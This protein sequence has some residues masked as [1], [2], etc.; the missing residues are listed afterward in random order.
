MSSAG[1][2]IEQH[3]S[4]FGISGASWTETSLDLPPDLQ[5]K[6]Y[7]AIGWALGSIRDM[8]AWGLGDWLNYGEAAYGER[9]AQAV[10]A[11]GRSKTTL[12]EYGRVARA[13]PRSRRRPS[14]TFTHHQLVAAR[15]PDEQEELLAAA[16]AEGWN[17]EEFRGF[18]RKTALST[19]RH[20]GPGPG[21][22]LGLLQDI[23][24]AILRAATHAEAGYAHVPEDL[25]DRLANALGE[26][27][28]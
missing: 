9:Y 3:G 11:T 17:I 8:S 27:R 18:L 19:R 6:D 2:A 12:L 23:A 4:A 25:L 14:L 24:R 16:E 1:L 10:E 21:E 28:P 15:H 22:V 26:Q 5:F 7:E 20:Q 13:V